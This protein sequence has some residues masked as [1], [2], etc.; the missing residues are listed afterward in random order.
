VV[1]QTAV[2]KVVTT[3]TTVQPVPPAATDFVAVPPPPPDTVGFISQHC[4][5]SFV[6]PNNYFSASGEVKNHSYD[7]RSYT[8]RT[9]FT[10]N[11]GVLASTTSAVGPIE[12]GA[13]AFFTA[14]AD[15]PAFVVSGQ[16]FNTTEAVVDITGLAC[17]TAIASVT[18]A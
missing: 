8:V 16:G 10:S 6:D 14:E 12:P 4:D 2:P 5:V 15:S 7:V 3:T 1:P 13:T 11:H 18:H 9:Q 17:S